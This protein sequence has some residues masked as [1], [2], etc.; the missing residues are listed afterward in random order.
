VLRSDQLSTKSTDALI[1]RAALSYLSSRSGDVI[2]VPQEFWYVAGR[3]STFA[4][5]HG[6]GH[7]YDTRVPLILF[8]GGVTAARN[9][10]SVSP[11]DIAP[12]LARAAGIRLSKAEGRV[13]PTAR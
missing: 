12:T 10:T 13:I 6:T 9:T 2:V 8:G 7:E 1:K 5:T 11:A 4:T 3:N